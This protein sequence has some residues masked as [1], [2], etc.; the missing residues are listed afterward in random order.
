MPT[1]IMTD[2]E[3]L[4]ARKLIDSIP[5]GSTVQEVEVALSMV[6]KKVLPAAKTVSLGD[7]TVEKF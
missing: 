4:L 1:M 5:V 6:R 7:Y 2:R 3:K